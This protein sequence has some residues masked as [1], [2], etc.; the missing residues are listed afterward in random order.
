MTAPSGD[1][2]ELTPGTEEYRQAIGRI[3]DDHGQAVIRAPYSGA[4]RKWDKGTYV[5]RI[6]KFTQKLIAQDRKQRDEL[7]IQQ[8]PAKDTRKHAVSGVDQ[9]IQIGWNAYRD[10]VLA[11][12][13]EQ[14]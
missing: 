14:A 12:L 5:L 3:L 13:R 10:E 2:S 7:R 8:L 1:A 11:I 4:F 9:G 6:E